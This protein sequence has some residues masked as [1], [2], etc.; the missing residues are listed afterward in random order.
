MPCHSCQDEPLILGGL[1]VTADPQVDRR[2]AK[3]RIVS[4]VHGCSDS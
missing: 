2:I 4:R 3:E 1:I